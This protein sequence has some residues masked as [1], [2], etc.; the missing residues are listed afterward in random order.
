MKGKGTVD[1]MTKREVKEIG[2]PDDTHRIMVLPGSPLLAEQMSGETD[3]YEADDEHIRGSIWTDGQLERLQQSDPRKY[4]SIMRKRQGSSANAVI[5]ENLRNS[6]KDCV[7]TEPTTLEPDVRALIGTT[8]KLNT[9]GAGQRKSVKGT[10]VTIK[11]F[12]VPTDRSGAAECFCV[13]AI[14]EGPIQSTVF[15]NV[16]VSLEGNIMQHGRQMTALVNWWAK[17][18]RRSHGQTS[19]DDVPR[20]CYSAVKVARMAGDRGASLPIGWRDCSCMQWSWA[21]LG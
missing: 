7:M 15:A 9:C 17:W 5:V 6:L 4:A 14:V 21:E 19:R 1:G 11:G 2:K 13:P 8:F 12:Y 20:D 3:G 16:V 18:K 10:A